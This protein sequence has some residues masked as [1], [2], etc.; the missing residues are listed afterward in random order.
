MPV[1]NSVNS[2]VALGS[3]FQEY[4]SW[5]GGGRAEGRGRTFSITP[6]DFL[7]GWD[8]IVDYAPHTTT[9]ITNEYMWTQVYCPPTHVFPSSSSTEHFWK[10][11]FK[12]LQ[13]LEIVIQ[14]D[15]EYDVYSGSKIYLESL[16]NPYKVGPGGAIFHSSPDTNLPTTTVVVKQ[17]DN[18]IR[19]FPKFSVAPLIHQADE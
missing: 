7:I 13:D 14:A 6:D 8:A 12:G 2:H 3:V 15:K 10:A 16:P 11:V 1:D 17:G 5:G 4:E 9:H 19:V 18:I